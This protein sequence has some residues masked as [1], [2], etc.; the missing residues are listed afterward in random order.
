MTRKQDNAKKTTWKA[1]MAEQEDFLRPLV[2]EV[3]HQVLEA[4]MAPRTGED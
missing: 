1:S 4:E 3:V 2:Q